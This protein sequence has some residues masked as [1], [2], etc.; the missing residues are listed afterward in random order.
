[1]TPTHDPYGRR[2]ADLE[3]DL[4]AAHDALDTAAAA[5][6]ACYEASWTAR[7]QAEEDRQ[8]ARWETLH[9]AQN[10]AAQRLH[11]AN[12]A[13]GRTPRDDRRPIA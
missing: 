6:A 8:L 4:A 1:M 5:A 12:Q 9:R 2:L 7:T 13:L 11:A 10:R 3:A